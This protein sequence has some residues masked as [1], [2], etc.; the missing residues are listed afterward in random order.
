[1]SWTSDR[2]R[3]AALIRDHPEDHDAIAVA[4]RDLRAARAEAYVREL[5]DTFPPL[6]EAQRAKLALI[7]HGGKG[8][9]ADAGAP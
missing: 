1:M 2:A 6:T 4:R 5:V 9:V 3:L 7:L 8:A